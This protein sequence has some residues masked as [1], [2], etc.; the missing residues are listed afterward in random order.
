M[1]WN[2]PAGFIAGAGISKYRSAHGVARFGFGMDEADNPGRMCV[3]FHIFDR[4]S[5]SLVKSSS[6]GVARRPYVH[7]AV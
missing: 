6:R 4:L 5:M 7:P 1:I 2:R 3:S